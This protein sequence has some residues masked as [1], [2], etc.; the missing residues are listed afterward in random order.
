MSSQAGSMFIQEISLLNFKNYEE[1]LI[2]FS[3]EINILTGDN[4]SGKTNLLDAIHYLSVSKSAFNITDSQSIKHNENFFLIS[5]T[6][7]KK[8]TSYLVQVSF[9]QGQK[10]LLKID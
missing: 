7:V 10:K 2:K 8:E 4:G 1:I 9:Q 3:P 6:I 5:S